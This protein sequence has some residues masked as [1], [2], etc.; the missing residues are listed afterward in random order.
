MVSP[1]SDPSTLLPL[2]PM[3][4]PSPLD[5]N[6]Q[7]LGLAIPI[8]SRVDSQ[9]TSSTTESNTRPPRR[10]NTSTS[11]DFSRLHLAPATRIQ[12]VTTTTT[13]TI[14]FAPILIPRSSTTTSSSTQST[15]TA[16]AEFAQHEE[17]NALVHLDPKLYPLS[18]SNWPGG[19][20]QQFRLALGELDASLEVDGGT[21]GY[22]YDD[23]EE[24]RGYAS[25]SVKGKGRAEVRMAS[26]RGAHAHRKKTRK[27]RTGGATAMAEDD[28][29]L[30]EMD[31]GVE[32]AGVARLPSPGP[33]RKRPRAGSRAGTESDSS[34]MEVEGEGEGEGGEGGPM[35]DYYAGALPSPN[36]SPPSPIPAFVEGDQGNST[37]EAIDLGS[38]HVLSGLLS[39]P[40][41]INTFDQLPP[42]LQSYFIFT[43]LKRSPVPVLQAINNIIAPSLRRDFLTDLPPELGIHILGY[44]DVVALC[45]ASV[46]CK[47][48][49]SLVDGEWRV[50]QERLVGDGLWIGDGS[51]AIEVEEINTGKKVNHFLE[52]WQS[53]VWHTKSVSLHLLPL[54]RNWNAH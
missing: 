48:W 37:E 16:L 34:E 1:R 54:E 52:R 27:S 30:E 10:H 32:I 35:R 23:E 39:L 38:G 50:W 4:N 40:D 51:E 5:V 36:Q 13:S 7:R 26:E 25:S 8:S 33:P 47:G 14:H 24:Q 9:T 15:A 12:R 20:S 21:V 43:F 28:D 41:F 53:G 18:Q 11:V 45:R 6:T 44:L 22:S 49:R 29:A 3:I 17:N 31:S 2:I 19:A 42:A 46:V